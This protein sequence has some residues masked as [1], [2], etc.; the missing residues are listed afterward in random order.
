[1]SKQKLSSV[2][3]EKSNLLNEAARSRELSI[4]FLKDTGKDPNAF[5]YAK[6]EDD[7]NVFTDLVSEFEKWKK[8]NNLN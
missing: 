4:K 8:D 1:M 5:M 3:N 7:S 2:T 6:W